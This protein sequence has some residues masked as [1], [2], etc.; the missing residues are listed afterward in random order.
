MAF[1]LVLFTLLSLAAAETDRYGNIM[2]SMPRLLQQ[3]ANVNKVSLP[4]DLDMGQL[5]VKLLKEENLSRFS[6]GRNISSECLNHLNMTVQALLQ[7]QV[8]ALQFLDATG[9]L[10]SGFLQ[11]NIFWLGRFEECLNTTATVFVGPNNT[12]PT[13]PFKGK[14]CKVGIPLG[15]T[16]PPAAELGEPDI[17]LGELQ[18]GVC[19]P[20]S[21]SREDTLTLINSTLALA[22]SAVPLGNSSLQANVAICHQENLK[23]DTRA[24]VSIT[25]LSFLGFLVVVGTV[26]D[27]FVIHRFHAS[28]EFDDLETDETEPLVLGS[29]NNSSSRNIKYRGY[30]SI[31][32]EN[33]S[34]HDAEKKHIQEE[35]EIGLGGKVLQAFSLY[36]NGSKLLSTHTG[37]GTLGAVNGIRFISMSWVILGH[38]YAFCA[39]IAKNIY[40]FIMGHVKQFSFMTILNATVAVDTFFLLSGL[41]VAY[42]SLKEMKKVGGARKFKWGMFYFHRFWRLTPTYGLIMLLYIPLMRYM[43]SGPFWQQNGTE[44]D[45]CENNFWMNLLYINNLWHSRDTCMLWSWY[46]A[47]DMQFYIVSPLLLIPLYFSSVFGGLV[48]FAF[49]IG[50]FTVTGILSSQNDFPMDILGTGGE[51]TNAAKYFDDIY[52]KP[53]CRIGPY[54]IGMIFGYI[55]YKTDCK[56]RITRFQNLLGWFLAA[57]CCLSTLYGNFDSVRGKHIP[58]KE[59][60]ALHNAVNPSVWALGVGWVVYACATGYGGIINS[61]LSWKLFVPLSRLTYISY[62]IHP[63]IME[64]YYNSKRDPLYITDF[65]VVYFFLGHLVLANAAAFVLSLVFE[66]PFMSLEKAVFRRA[67][68]H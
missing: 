22:S 10:S 47:N 32:T 20:S 4:N 57:V 43:S 53:Y 2:K 27:V 19:I 31:H 48:C 63:V 24:V 15:P 12:T 35:D 14:Y 23:L 38:S 6:A 59:E 7:R 65:D 1:I 52:T 55:L 68:R 18:L 8:W 25:I 21:C 62:L 61:F 36:T 30:N 11:G 40:P 9:K 13:H 45:F 34:Q 64:I 67:K 33:E 50:S 39:M 42:L 26:Y 56:K 54:V 66:S 46:M 28:P 3:S 58:S 44:K 16:Q 41:L 49:L 60:S 5:Y 17:P 37:A 51:P 29:Q